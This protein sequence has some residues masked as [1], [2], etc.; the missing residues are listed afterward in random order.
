MTQLDN[1]EIEESASKA[2]REKMGTVIPT[3]DLSVLHSNTTGKK[4][5]E[6]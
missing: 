5:L 6:A 1:N 3:K 2:R 4:T